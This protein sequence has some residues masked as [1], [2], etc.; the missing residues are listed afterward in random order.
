MSK[1]FTFNLIN[2][3]SD[4]DFGKIIFNGKFVFI[5]DDE[6]TSDLWSKIGFIPINNNERQIESDDLFYYLNSRLPIS[7][8]K[9]DVKSKLE[10]IKSNGLR[11]ASD[12]FVLRSA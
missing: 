4:V 7:L 2:E 10:Y 9:T 11:V 5:L 3:A 12:S 6:I 1:A 8:R